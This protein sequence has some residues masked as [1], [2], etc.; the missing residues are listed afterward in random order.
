MSAPA[1][2]G[3]RCPVSERLKIGAFSAWIYEAGGLRVVRDEDLARATG[4]DVRSLRAG[5]SETEGGEL[6][7]FFARDLGRTVHGRPVGWLHGLAEL[8]EWQ[9]PDPIKSLWGLLRKH[10]PPRPKGAA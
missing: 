9:V 2:I 3:T 5:A 4:I 7:A 8:K 1:L 6:V 10:G